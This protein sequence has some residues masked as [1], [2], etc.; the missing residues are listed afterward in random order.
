MHLQQLRALH[1]VVLYLHRDESHTLPKSGDTLSGVSEFKLQQLTLR[2][3]EGFLLK[4][5]H[6]TI[7]FAVISGGV[8]GD[9]MAIN[10]VGATNR[11][12]LSMMEVVHWTGD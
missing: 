6:H 1:C 3:V 5:S 4:I 2:S 11:G 8:G 10:I 9:Y 7:H 12:W